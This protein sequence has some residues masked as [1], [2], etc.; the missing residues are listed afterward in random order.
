MKKKTVFQELAINN[1]DFSNLFD[2]VLGLYD[3][4]KISKIKQEPLNKA[5]SNFIDKLVRYSMLESLREC[6]SDSVYDLFNLYVFI[7]ELEQQL[8]D[9]NNKSIP[10]NFKFTL[11]Y[12]VKGVEQKHIE[13][14]PF[15][16]IRMIK[17]YTENQIEN[18]LPPMYG[19]NDQIKNDIE[20]AKSAYRELIRQ[21]PGKEI[22]H[23]SY[24]ENI[25]KRWANFI[26]S[27]K[28]KQRRPNKNKEIT[29]FAI[30]LKKILSDADTK[31]YKTL[32][33]ENARFIYSLFV[34]LNIVSDER[35]TAFE[36]VNY[37][38]ALIDNYTKSKT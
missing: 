14:D 23:P 11:S 35:D 7:S 4:F 18:G 21:N 37:I 36:G 31:K 2:K 27:I 22:P 29:L 24:T 28:Q 34:I 32:S 5:I 17:E 6:E 26:N 12:T 8:F 20:D 15:L 19:I 33:S 38:K 1:T 30:E 10:K 25:I 9:E 16:I 3:K 13:N